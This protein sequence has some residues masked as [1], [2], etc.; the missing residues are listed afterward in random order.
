MKINNTFLNKYHKFIHF[1]KLK[2]TNQKHKQTIKIPTYLSLRK[3]TNNN[4][5]SNYHFDLN[6]ISFH[7]G[8]SIEFGHYTSKK[9]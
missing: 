5:Q 2:N 3:Y 4:N 6:S 1:F 8:N 7:H 9:T